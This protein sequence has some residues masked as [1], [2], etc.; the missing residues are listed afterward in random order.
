MK[1]NLDLDEIKYIKISYKDVLNE[2]HSMKAAIKSV[3]DR[4]ITACTKFEDGLDI[5]TPQEI[6]LSIVNK[7][8]LY[9]TKTILKSFENDEPYIFFFLST[10]NGLEYQQNREYFR[11]PINLDCVYSVH[12]YDEVIRINATT[13]NLSANGICINIPNLVVAEQDAYISFS[14]QNK[15]IE[16]KLKYIRSEKTNTGYSASFAFINLSETDRD[17]ISQICIKKQLEQKRSSLY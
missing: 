3:N 6:T 8:G 1:F 4:E 13:I 15:K 11:V 9:K 14:A 2:T 5:E 16:V 17:L 12:Q 7:D 10:P